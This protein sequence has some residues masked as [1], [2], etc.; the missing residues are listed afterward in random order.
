MGKLYVIGIGPGGLDEMTLRAVKAI[1][2]SDIIVG[3]TKYIE[4]VKDLIKDKEIFKTGMRGE[5]ER[6]REALELSKDKK[7][8][9][10]S[11]GDS[12][13][14]GM[15]GL[16][17]EMRKDENVEI[18]PGITAS[19]AAGSVLGAPLMHDNCNISLS[20]LMTPYEDI[21]KRVRFAAEGDFVISLYNPKSKGRP[22]Y[23]RECVDIIKEFRG[24]ETPIAVVRNALREGESKEI[25]TLKDFN[26][27]VV[28]MFSIVIIGN[29]KSY[30]KDGYFVTPR[31][32]KIKK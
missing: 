20:D 14:Y 13:I 16:I 18:I 10:I 19:S 30:I 27:E 28:D 17:L 23:L 6:C 4:M 25:F 24:E 31:G 5:E 9:L 21:K 7:V 32:Y 3:Y 1:E 11:T 26:D 12:G 8:A 22:H 29:S 15:A 2:E